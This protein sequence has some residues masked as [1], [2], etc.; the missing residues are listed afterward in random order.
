MSTAPN[1]DE[2]DEVVCLDLSRF[3]KS[4]REHQSAMTSTRKPTNLAMA[5]RKASTDRKIWTALH[6]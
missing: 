4:N 1:L 6:T 3:T 5:G 2:K